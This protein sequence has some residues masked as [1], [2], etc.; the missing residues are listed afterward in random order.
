MRIQGLFQTSLYGRSSSIPGAAKG[1]TRNDS[2]GLNGNTPRDIR[3]M[4]AQA[5][6]ES[7]DRFA[8]SGTNQIISSSLNY[9]S[10]LKL[11][12]DKIKDTS[13]E[14]KKL[15]YQFK[16]ISSKILRSKTSQAARQVVSQ[17]KREVLRLKQEKQSGKYDEEE[18]DAA[19]SHAKACERVAKK[20]ERHLLEE[21]MARAAGGPC[22]EAY[23]ELN[24]K[25]REKSRENAEKEQ[26]DILLQENA[27]GARTEKL[28][29]DV[30]QN[31]TEQMQEVLQDIR[32]E[33][34]EALQNM[35]DEM[36]EAL[37]NMSEEMQ[38]MLQDMSDELQEMLEE[39]GFGE[40]LDSFAAIRGDMDPNDLKMLKIKHRCK[41]MKELVKADSE[42]LKAVFKHME[43]KTAGSMPTAS[44]S[45]DSVPTASMPATSVPTASGA[46]GG[47]VIDIS[48]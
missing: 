33:M 44:M 42:Y 46:A 43:T 29:Y 35:S 37:Q 13:L 27:T 10:Q 17:A 25:Q 1:S 5:N 47:A 12:R 20:K 38:G 39:M 6:R 4:V 45:T 34:Q 23:E 14:K 40:G 9:G 22:A 3:S 26:G 15:K 16:N 8:F 21:E 36:Q 32:G 41:E 24:E 28:P 18:I 7:D 2:I 19:I 48:L 30:L 31:L 11:Q